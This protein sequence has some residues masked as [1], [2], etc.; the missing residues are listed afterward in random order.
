MPTTSRKARKRA[1]VERSKKR[2]TTSCKPLPPT[3]P[4]GSPELVITA[5]AVAEVLTCAIGQDLTSQEEL[6]RLFRRGLQTDFPQA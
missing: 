4:L 6:W 1:S 5:Q 3:L 2:R